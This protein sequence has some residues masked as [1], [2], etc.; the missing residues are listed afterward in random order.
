MLPFYWNIERV[1]SEYYIDVKEYDGSDAVKA[2]DSLKNKSCS[3][4]EEGEIPINAMVCN[5]KVYNGKLR[6]DNDEFVYWLRVP[7]F[8]D[9]TDIQGDWEHSDLIN[10]FIKWN[11][12]N[13]IKDGNANGGNTFWSYNIFKDREFAYR[14]SVFIIDNFGRTSTNGFITKGQV[15]WN[16]K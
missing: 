15:D 6:Q 7:C 16:T 4:Y 1:S 8:T 9:G 14:S 13:F 3:N 2:Y 10:A 5:F 11:Q 12:N